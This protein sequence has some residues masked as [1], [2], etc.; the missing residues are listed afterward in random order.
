MAGAWSEQQNFGYGRGLFPVNL[1]KW[2]GFDFNNKWFQKK[3]FCCG[4]DEVL[5]C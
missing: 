4:K 2:R 5:D 3:P 1:L